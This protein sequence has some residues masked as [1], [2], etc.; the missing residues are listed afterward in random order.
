MPKRE[1]QFFSISNIFVQ[2]TWKTVVLTILNHHASRNN[3]SSP[4]YSQFFF[5]SSFWFVISLINYIKPRITKL[6]IQIASLNCAKRIYAA[7][8]SPEHKA[9][10]V[11]RFPNLFI[12]IVKFY[13][14]YIYLC[15]CIY[16]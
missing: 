14:P 4:S 13:E 5:L 11:V 16:I 15:V 1:A 3:S 7:A 12:Y 2:F 10:L 8:S 6:A 9:Q